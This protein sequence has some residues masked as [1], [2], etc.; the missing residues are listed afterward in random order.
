MDN[1]PTAATFSGVQDD[2]MTFR[3]S[4]AYTDMMADHAVDAETQAYQS[5]LASV[6]RFFSLPAGVLGTHYAAK[7][8]IKHR[9][10]RAPLGS[11]EGTLITNLQSKGYTVDT[12]AQHLIVY[13]P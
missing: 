11:M 7:A 3:A 2:A 8:D 9:I 10:R 5:A 6:G 1:I 12:T 13:C 4:Q